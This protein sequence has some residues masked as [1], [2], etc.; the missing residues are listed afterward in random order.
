MSLQKRLQKSQTK[1]GPIEGNRYHK[2][3]KVNDII[4]AGKSL[5]SDGEG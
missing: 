2:T 5:L 3:N 4:C 1:I